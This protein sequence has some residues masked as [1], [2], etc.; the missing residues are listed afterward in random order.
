M[1]KYDIVIIG[2]GPA[3]LYAANEYITQLSSGKVSKKNI[4]IIDKGNSL[5]K[6]I[7][8]IN[9][10]KVKS[11]IKCKTCSIMEGFGGAGAYSDGKFNI[12]NE[13]GGTLWQKIGLE[14]STRLMEKVDE[15]NKE[16]SKG[17]G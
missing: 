10:G 4:L 16:L 6:R 17:T 9:E 12:T 3:G 13:F 15:V 1:K 7:C 8:P 11:C 14:T 2:T 5:D